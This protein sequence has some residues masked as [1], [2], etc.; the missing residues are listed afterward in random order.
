M[1]SST[2]L[3][4][5]KGARE[6]A[7]S[8]SY[9][10]SSEVEKVIVAPGNDLIAYKRE[11]EVIVEKNCSLKDPK[12]ILKVADKYRPDIIDVAQ[13]DALSRGTVDLLKQNSYKVFG[14]TK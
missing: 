5:G 8:F 13:D 6:H 12:S 9:E 1:K 10:K 4:V 7:L 14:P 2:V 3:I 11:K